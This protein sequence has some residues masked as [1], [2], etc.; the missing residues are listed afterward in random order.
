VAV[1]PIHIAK[2]TNPV[3]T[4][5]AVELHDHPEL[6]IVDI[7]LVWEARPRLLT[8]APWQAVRTLDVAQIPQL[9]WRFGSNLNVGKQVAQ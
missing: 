9:D 3:M 6:L 8:I 2:L 7:G 4:G 5:T 1:I